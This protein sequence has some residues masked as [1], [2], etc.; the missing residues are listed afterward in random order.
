MFA[1][2]GYL[3]QKEVFDN[4]SHKD[5]LEI[6]IDEHGENQSDVKAFINRMGEKNLKESNIAKMVDRLI[7]AQ[8]KSSLDKLTSGLYFI[9]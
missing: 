9:H 2:L 1:F 6:C 7:T 4:L 8:V 5:I 3:A